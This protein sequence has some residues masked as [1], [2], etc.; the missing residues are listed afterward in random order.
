MATNYITT[1]TDLTAVADAIRTKGGT[2]ASLSWPSGFAT[3]I[4]NIP[5]SGGGDEVF[6]QMITRTYPFAS[7]VQTISTSYVG[8]GAFAWT[9]SA[10]IALSF[11]NATEISDYAFHG[12]SFEQLTFP[13]CT[14][15]G[16]H[17]FNNYQDSNIT[18]TKM[19]VVPNYAFYSA[20][21]THLTDT[22]FPS[23][24]IVQSSACRYAR[25]T[26]V[27]LSKIVSAYQYAF[28]N[29]TALTDVSLPSLKGTLGIAAFTSCTALTTITLPSVGILNNA[30]FQ[31]CT[32]LTAVYLPK[33]T[34]ISSTY[35]F[36]SC[37]NLLS[38]YLLNSTM[39]TLTS[40]NTFASTPISNYTTSTGGVY[41]SIYVPS[42]LLA[43]Y[44]AATNWKT[45]S[46][47]FVGLTS[48]QIA[49]L[50]F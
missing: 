1:A 36:R 30:A 32:N 21:F 11:P 40:T 37:Y 18:F 7:P 31:G 45:Y 27:S 50:G 24:T 17:A 23:A 34:K 3:A 10:N 46:A 20:S 19:S 38:L 41:G 14:T 12:A 6:N 5:T 29:C 48:E 16:S 44:Q 2:S 15:I 26:T 35:A 13:N 49:A 43:S 8:S 22:M 9:R 28:A 4:A 42:A 39:A 47:R 25:L 33:C